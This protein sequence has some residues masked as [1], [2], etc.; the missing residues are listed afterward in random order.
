VRLIS[1]EVVKEERLK[2][3]GMDEKMIYVVGYKNEKFHLYTY[4]K[5]TLVKISRKK[6]KGRKYSLNQTFIYNQNIYTLSNDFAKVDSLRKITF[7]R[8]TLDLKF[9]SKQVYIIN[10][11]FR[12]YDNFLY[13]FK[14][15]SIYISNRDTGI[16]EKVC[17]LNFINYK[18]S[19]IY[20]NI[21]EK[22]DSSNDYF[23]EIINYENMNPNIYRRDDYPFVKIGKT[24]NEQKREEFDFYSFG[25]KYGLEKD[26]LESN[27]KIKKLMD[28]F[29]INVDKI[30]PNNFVNG[31]K[32]VVKFA[33]YYRKDK[34]IVFVGQY[35]EDVGTKVNY[36]LFSYVINSKN[37]LESDVE[38]HLLASRNKNEESLPYSND[39]LMA[40]RDLNTQNKL[41]AENEDETIFIFNPVSQSKGGWGEYIYVQD[42]YIVK[43]KNSGELKINQ[44][45]FIQQSNEYNLM[46]INPIVVGDICYLFFLEHKDTDKKGL[47][48]ADLLKV[49]KLNLAYIKID[50]LTGEVSEKVV[51]GDKSNMKFSPRIQDIGAYY[52]EVE[53]K[54]YYFMMGEEPYNKKNV[55][56]QLVFD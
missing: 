50:L 12:I 37:E 9:I 6:I 56:Y 17:K 16:L 3:I 26:F 30:E 1:S 39:K 53:N 18:K 14:D 38:F 10:N 45:P 21:N 52:N 48:L 20:L 4:D 51:V 29:K 42:I 54:Y 46:G 24:F 11:K 55:L 34:R 47:K 2:V 49:K 25:L 43:V 27:I 19:E 31:N 36:G 41:I 22:I 28:S 44:L 5:K 15:S 33:K 40:E 7:K 35:T 8:Y 13:S 32:L 23:F